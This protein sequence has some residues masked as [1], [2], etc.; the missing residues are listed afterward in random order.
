VIVGVGFSMLFPSLALMVVGEVADERRGAAMGA[1]TAFFDIGV[2]LGGPICG[3]T[4]S[5]AGYPAVFVLSAVA[6]LG[7]AIL[8]AA[9][10]EQPSPIVATASP[11]G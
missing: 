3:V 7:T 1:F 6:A 11:P 9:P 4:A 2:G 10:R 5:V 8:A